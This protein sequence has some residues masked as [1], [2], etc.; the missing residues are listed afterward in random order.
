MAVITDGE[1]PESSA[2]N[3][4]GQIIMDFLEVYAETPAVYQEA[5]KD[6]ELAYTNLETFLK[7]WQ[8]PAEGDKL[9]KIKTEL[10]DVKDIMHKN[11][12]ELMNRG[13]SLDSMM[14]K[15]KDLSKMSREFY[16]KAKTKNQRC[17]TLS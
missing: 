3:L 13:E 4:I 16:R 12:D 6:K 7:N 11:M 10:D 14:E 1:Y 2:F 8:N 15:S 9:Y 5:Y 17:C